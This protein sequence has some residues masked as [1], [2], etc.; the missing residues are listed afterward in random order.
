MGAH[1]TASKAGLVGLAR[2][3]AKELGPRGLQVNV[4]APGPME[5]DAP[6]P[7]EARQRFEHAVALRR[8]GRASDVAGV[9]M[10]L[11]SDLAAFVSGET[12]NVDG[13]V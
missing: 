10:F 8:L 4:V 12:F 11:A 7:P 9:A 3:L 5:S 13:G 6:M 2:S 1:Y